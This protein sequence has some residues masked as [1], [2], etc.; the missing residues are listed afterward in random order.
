MMSSLGERMKV[1]T[2][3]CECASYMMI[4]LEV[5]TGGKTP[6]ER[7]KWKRAEVMGLRK[8]EKLNARWGYCLFFGVKARS[9]ELIA[10]DGEFGMIKYV[11]TVRRIPEEWVTVVPW[12]RGQE[13]KVADGDLPEFDVKNGPGRRLTL[14]K[15]KD[16]QMNEAL[17]SHIV[18]ICA[19]MTSASTA[20]WTGLRGVRL[21]CEV[22]PHAV[23]HGGEQVADGS[24]LG[25]GHQD[26]ECQG[27]DAG[28]GLEGQGQR[29]RGQEH[30][31]ES[32]AGEL[33]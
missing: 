10:I 11:R 5:A 16:I 15:K 9:N 8:L 29:S 1:N 17:A 19:N 6:Y 21:C 7:I 27:Q 14:E 22:L 3:L 23:L 18:H 25:V 26:Q 32:K 33:R 20:S 2:W 12:S 28:A 31:E 13:D 4:R 24:G 30:D